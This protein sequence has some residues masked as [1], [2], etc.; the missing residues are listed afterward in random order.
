MHL[1]TLSLHIGP[2]ETKLSENCQGWVKI[3]LGL[4]GNPLQLSETTV[5][6]NESV[7]KGVCSSFPWSWQNKSEVKLL[8][9]SE[10][11]LGPSENSPEPSE[12]L[13]GRM[14]V[15]AKA[16][17]AVRCPSG[18]ALYCQNKSEW[19]SLR[20]S[21]NYSGAKWKSIGAQW[22]YFLNEC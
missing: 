5:G 6:L 22:K 3:I 21:K 1:Y 2:I 17:A 15:C 19:K 20:L 9:L 12:K 10:I 11:I 8:R 7:C 16:C 4:S 18:V 14:K 13:W